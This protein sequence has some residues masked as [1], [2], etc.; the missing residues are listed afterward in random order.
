VV[1]DEFTGAPL[2]YKLGRVVE[3]IATNG[4]AKEAT[5]AKGSIFLKFIVFSLMD[6]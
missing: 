6:D 4:S 1:P 3:D 2:I 5:T